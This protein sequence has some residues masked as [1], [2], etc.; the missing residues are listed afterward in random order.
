MD[1][2]EWNGDVLVVGAGAAG[3]AAARKLA[4]AGLRVLVAEGRD[5]PG[6]RAWSYPLGQS[7]VPAEIGAEFIHGPAPQTRALLREAGMADVGTGGDSWVFDGDRLQQ[8]NEDF[9]TAARLFA[10]AASLERDQSVDAFLRAYE[11]DDSTRAAA[12][13][14]RAFAE[15]FDAVDPALAGARSI[16][17]EWQSGVDSLTA[18]PLGGYRRLLEFLARACDDDGVRIA[19]RSQIEQ[20]VWRPGEVTAHTRFADGERRALRARAIVVT[21]PVAVLRA[22]AIRFEPPL[23][24]RKN[25]A[26]NR[27]ETGRVVRVV[28]GFKR[29]FWETIEGARYREAGFFRS[30][31]LAFAAYW[32]QVPTR[33]PIIGAWAGGPK[34]SAL[35][36][37]SREE[38]IALALD[39]FGTLFGERELA[40]REFDGAVMH[41]WDADPC[42]FGA[43]SYL[44][45]D[46]VGARD[47]L[48]APVEATLFFAGEATAGNGEGGTVNGALRSG[49]RAASEVTAAI[50]ARA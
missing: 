50:G 38:L 29:A 31:Q 26:L 32:T 45:V 14:A 24:A 8:G 21:V 2:E 49:E 46:G 6:G 9:V 7:G 16:G 15:G 1:I 28:L 5:R 19:L 23:D 47:A 33:A 25:E 30:P 34:A 35:A 12:H 40:Q 37:R 13:A 3:L 27:I 43:Y 41:D 36:G 44:A 39:N 18:R 42:A 20:V 11:S 48:A 10:K 4:R 22:N 17:E